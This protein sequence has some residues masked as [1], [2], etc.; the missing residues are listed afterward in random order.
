MMTRDTGWNGEIEYF[1]ERRYGE[2][3]NINQDVRG[4]GGIYNQF[5]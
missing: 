1:Q 5:R 3:S 2:R 4:Y